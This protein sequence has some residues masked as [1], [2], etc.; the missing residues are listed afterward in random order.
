M[1]FPDYKCLKVDLWL[2]VSEI[3]VRQNI[4][5]NDLKWQQQEIVAKKTEKNFY[6]QLRDN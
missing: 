6:V 5:A 4:L 2:L 3:T 1:H